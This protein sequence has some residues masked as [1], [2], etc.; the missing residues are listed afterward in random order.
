MGAV[1]LAL[2]TVVAIFP[3]VIAH[4]DPNATIYPRSLGP[5][6]RHLLGTTALG[7][8]IFSQLVWGTRQVL[9]IAVAV[10]LLATVIAVLVGVSAAYLG[11]ARDGSL[12]SSPT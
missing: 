8:D 10:G 6:A 7:Q 12:A 9:I 3:G 5:S 11:G 2:F 1:L 4:D